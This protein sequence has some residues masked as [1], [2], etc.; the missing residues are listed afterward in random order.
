MGPDDRH[1]T[2]DH[3]DMLGDHWL[4]AVEGFYDAA[5]HVPLIIRVPGEHAQRSRIVQAFTESVDVLPTIVELL[6][7]KPPRQCDGASLVPFIE[8]SDPVSWRQ[9]AHWEYDFRDTLEPFLQSDLSLG[10]D[11]ASLAVIRGEQWK[12]VHFSALE[13]LLFNLLSDPFEMR[14]A[15][16]TQDGPARALEM[17]RDLLSWRMRSDDRTLSGAFVTPSGLSGVI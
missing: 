12:Y 17:S 5:F 16:R 3:G 15:S 7:G 2:A 10:Q 13:P 8:G 14:D 6:G 11:E 4:W 9:C 1:P